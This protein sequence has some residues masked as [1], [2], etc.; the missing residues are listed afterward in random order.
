MHG[1]DAYALPRHVTSSLVERLRAMPGLVAVG[2]RQT[3]KSTLV[4][5]SVR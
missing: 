3:D 2:V 1:V 5:G 4:K